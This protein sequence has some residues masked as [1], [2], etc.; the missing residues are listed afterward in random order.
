MCRRLL[1]LGTDLQ[2]A[3]STDGVRRTPSKGLSS[4]AR[5]ILDTASVVVLVPG[6]SGASS[7][8]LLAVGIG[9]LVRAFPGVDATVTRQRTRIAERLCS[10][11]ASPSHASLLYRLRAYLATALA[12]VRFL[13]GVDPLVDCQSGP[14]DELLAAVREVADVR[15]DATVDALWRVCV[16]RRECPTRHPL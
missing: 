7:E 15:P 3:G 10:K 12:H 2:V 4:G 9:A 1:A 8:R 13:T 11:S 6:E 14:L 5:S 16:S